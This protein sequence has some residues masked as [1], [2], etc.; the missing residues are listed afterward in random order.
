MEI[1]NTENIVPDNNI[2]MI[3]YGR[4][5]V[6]KT[7]F[8]A[9]A[10]KPLIIDFENGTK[11]LGERGL[12]CDVIRMA[13]WFTA[14]DKKQLKELLPKYKTIVLDPIGDAMEKLIASHGLD[15][16]KYR[17]PDGGLTIA[18]W[19]EAKRQMKELIKW[20]RDAGKNVILIAHVA[21]VKDGE[22]VT[23]R[24]Q[25]QTK[26]SDEL[27][28]MVDIISYMGVQKK[29]GKNVVCLYT[30]AS[31]GPYDS[32]DRTG[33]V[34]ELVEVSEKNGWNDFISSFRPIDKMEKNDDSSKHENTQKSKTTSSADALSRK[35]SI[36][37]RLIKEHAQELPEGPYQM[38]KSALDSGDEE[39]IE[40]M[41][42]R[43]KSYL[44]KKG[45]KV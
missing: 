19:G 14:D 11:F 38:A 10:D 16:R 2:V 9:T 25:I 21:E 27:P 30:P 7:T 35:K 12:Q 44:S 41:I 13:E 6:G 22:Q 3:L 1:E 5:G 40:A 33:R 15:S 36:L 37:D 31:G 42:T 29:D 24:I 8:A 4:G 43:V 28:T 39:A 17:A 20:L 23:Y 34:P 32:K 18:G 26:L 45:V